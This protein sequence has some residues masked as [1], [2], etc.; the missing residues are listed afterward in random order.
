MC[1]S[2]PCLF[3]HRLT[4]INEN[5]SKH[6]ALAKARAKIGLMLYKTNPKARAGTQARPSPSMFL[7]FD[8][9]SGT[10]GEGPTSCGLTFP[11]H[12]SSVGGGGPY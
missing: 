4:P 6:W 12:G 5:L 10:D 11:A 1:A 9:S 3:R 2:G 7:V 8:L